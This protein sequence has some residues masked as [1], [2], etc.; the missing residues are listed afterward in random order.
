M[1]NTHSL[2]LEASSSQFAAIADASQTGLD[3]SGD[4]TI[5]AWVNWESLPTSGFINFILEKG[6]INDISYH[7]R[8]YNASGTYRL[9]AVISNNGTNYDWVYCNITTPTTGTWY[10][11]AV[12]CD[13]SN[14]VATEFEFFVDGT[15][16]GNGTVLNDGS[17][18]GIYNNSRAVFI[19]VMEGY[20]DAAAKFLDGKID[21]VRVWNVIRSDA[22]INTYKRKDV[23]GQT[24]LVAYWKLNNSALDE[25]ANNNDLT[26]YGSPSYS[27]SV[28]FTT[29]ISSSGFMSLL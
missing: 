9:E 19:G 14:A 13:I 18:T 24:G 5:E 12:T 7:F 20:A 27:T 1:P 15:S 21:E 6:T 8:V 10:H 2:D 26:L 17:V 16:Q 23:T 11:Y 29:Y 4:F 28:P 22:D 25:T 3:L